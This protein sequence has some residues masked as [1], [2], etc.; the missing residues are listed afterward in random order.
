MLLLPF[1]CFLILLMIIYGKNDPQSFLLNSIKSVI[2]ISVYSWFNIEILSLFKGLNYFNISFSWILFTSILILYLLKN[3][4]IVS[5]FNIRILTV[6]WST[7]CP[8]PSICSKQLGFSNIS[9]ST[10]NS[11]V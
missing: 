5:R 7:I 4:N 1:V 9:P 3:K 8:R 2:L 11:L 6:Y 10:H